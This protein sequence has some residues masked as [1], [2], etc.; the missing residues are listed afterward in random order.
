VVARV[1][2]AL[3]HVANRA[4]C[5]NELLAG[6]LRDILWQTQSVA[7]SWGYWETPQ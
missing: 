5:R 1:R 3:L 4:L 2:K 7:R 6:S